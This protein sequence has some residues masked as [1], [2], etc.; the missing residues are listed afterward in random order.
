MS[1]EA[2]RTCPAATPLQ[3]AGVAQATAAQAVLTPP[4]TALR[5]KCFTHIA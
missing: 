3:P 2:A 5:A 1:P 4:A